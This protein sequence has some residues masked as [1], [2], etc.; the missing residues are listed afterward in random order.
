[1]DEAHARAHAGRGRRTR[2]VRMHSSTKKA[3]KVS[4]GDEVGDSFISVTKYGISAYV[5]TIHCRV[6]CPGT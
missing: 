2:R 1:M 3:I 6:D 5:D 4:Q